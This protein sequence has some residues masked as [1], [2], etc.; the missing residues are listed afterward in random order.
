[1]LTQVLS[2][3]G[4][5]FFIFF[6]NV[7]GAVSG[8][9]STT[10]RRRAGGWDSGGLTGS[11]LQW[12]SSDGSDCVVPCWTQ[13]SLAMWSPGPVVCPEDIQSHTYVLASP[14]VGVSGHPDLGSWW[15][16]GLTHS[17]WASEACSVQIR[18]SAL[19]RGRGEPLGA[20]ELSI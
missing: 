10:Q 3:S 19:D 6:E 17:W 9:P 12:R 2:L 4:I 7:L 8:S 14:W 5:F 13:F 11:G 15:K 20:S 16:C 18:G 1:M